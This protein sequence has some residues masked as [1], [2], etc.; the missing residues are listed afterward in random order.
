[1]VI[2]EGTAAALRSLESTWDKFEAC[3]KVKLHGTA[4]NIAFQWLLQTVLTNACKQGS[5]SSPRPK[6]LSATSEFGLR[7]MRGGSNLD[8]SKGMSNGIEFFPLSAMLARWCLHAKCWQRGTDSLTLGISMAN[9]QMAEEADRCHTFSDAPGF[10]SALR[11]VHW[12][13]AVV[14]SWK[15]GRWVGLLD[16]WALQVLYHRQWKLYTTYVSTYGMVWGLW[17]N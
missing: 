8:E 10:A 3:S 1:M 7:L 12:I 13:C 14:A 16:E 17:S 5:K 11:A 4:L 2:V 9:S 6:W 15:M